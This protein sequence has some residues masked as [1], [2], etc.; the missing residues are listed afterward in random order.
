MDGWMGVG[1]GALMLARLLCYLTLP[2][3]TL[4]SLVLQV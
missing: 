3:P 2:R 1:V 4:L